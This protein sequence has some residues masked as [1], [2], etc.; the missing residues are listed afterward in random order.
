MVNEPARRLYLHIALA[1][2]VLSVA[3]CEAVSNAQRWRVI[4]SDASLCYTN[5]QR[6]IAAGQHGHERRE[7]ILAQM[8]LLEAVLGMAEQAMTDGDEAGRVAE[9][10]H[11]ADEVY[12]SLIVIELEGQE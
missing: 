5:L 9:L 2:I 1:S 12:E 7:K 10:L 11:R 4:S 6:Q 8:T 3:G